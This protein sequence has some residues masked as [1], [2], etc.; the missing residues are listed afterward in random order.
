M[1]HYSDN[2]IPTMTNYTTPSGAASTGN[3]SYAFRAFD[4]NPSSYWESAYYGQITW[5]RYK[6]DSPQIIVKYTVSAAYGTAPKNWTFEGSNDALTWDILDTR[7]NEISWDGSV[8]CYVFN[9]NK[10]YLYYQLNIKAHNGDLYYSRVNEIEMMGIVYENKFL[11]LKDDNAYGAVPMKPLVPNLKSAVGENGYVISSGAYTANWFAFDGDNISGYATNFVP[12]AGAPAYVGYKFNTPVTVKKYEFLAGLI[13]F[14]LMASND[15][16]SWVTLDTRTNIPVNMTTVQSYIVPKA[17]S[18]YYYKLETTKATSVRDWVTFFVV[19]FYDYTPV[20][21]TP[22]LEEND[23]S[24]YGFVKEDE[25]DLEKK[26]SHMLIKTTNNSSVGSGKVF[27][28]KIDTTKV[29]IK[30]SSIT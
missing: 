23:Y 9:N 19:Q 2:L 27:R 11:I 7:T 5:L 8:R 13:D 21:I 3:S 30:K 17:S 16:V 1:A 12:S 28:Q 29:P 25:I 26:H 24:T 15:G 20:I 6:F 4:K 14:K 18:Y 10:E 22:T